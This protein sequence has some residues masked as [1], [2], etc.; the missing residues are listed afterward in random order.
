MENGSTLFWTLN[1]NMFA[2]NCAHNMG[3]IHASWKLR[4]IFFHSSVDE[5]GRKYSPARAS[6]IASQVS[7]ITRLRVDFPVRYANGNDCCDSPDVRKRKVTA[8]LLLAHIALWK[9]VFSFVILFSTNP[10][11]RS[12]RSGDIRIYL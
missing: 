9:F 10:S 12:N 11:K 4:A 1:S 8:S 7:L 3:E 2:I 5:G 6:N